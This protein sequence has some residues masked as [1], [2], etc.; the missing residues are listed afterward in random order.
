MNVAAENERAVIGGNKPPIS[1]V[2]FEQYKPLIDRL[3]PLAALVA[4]LPKDIKSEEDLSKASDKIIETKALAKDLEAARKAEKDPHVKTG[5][6]IDSFFNALI[7]KVDV[8]TDGLE[9]SANQYQRDKIAEE[10]RKKDEEARKARDEEARLRQAALDA[11]R[12]DTA[13]RREDEADKAAARASEAT[14]AAAELSAKSVKAQT[15]SGVKLNTSTFWNFRIVSFDS[16]PLDRLR[17]FIDADAIE[18]AVKKF[19]AVRKGRTDLPGVEVFEDVK[20]SFRR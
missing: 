7:A 11:K 2:L 15:D 3:A 5:K 4:A 13:A 18:T 16:I 9:G 8:L 6:A 17:D 19:V 14:D 1:E 10:R 20:T 12:P